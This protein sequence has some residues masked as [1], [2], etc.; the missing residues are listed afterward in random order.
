MNY[1]NGDVFLDD[2]GDILIVY[3]DWVKGE[4]GTVNILTVH[5]QENEVLRFPLIHSGED[6][7]INT[8]EGDDIEDIPPPKFL[9]NLN[10][11]FSIIPREFE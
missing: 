5:K 1:K 10:E 7:V 11:L 6:L 9:F 2:A 8:L 4:R 3:H